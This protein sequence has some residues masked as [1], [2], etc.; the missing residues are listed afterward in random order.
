MNSEQDRCDPR[1]KNFRGAISRHK[2]KQQL[3][4]NRAS[5]QPVDTLPRS[6]SN[7]G[8]KISRI[9]S[10]SQD[11]L[12]R[13][14]SN[15]L[16]SA[17]LQS[18]F[19]A[20]IPSRITQPGA[21]KSIRVCFLLSMVLFA[22]TSL[23]MGGL[24]VFLYPIWWLCAV[25]WVFS[26]VP[27]VFSCVTSIT[28]STL[29]LSGT[30]I[31]NLVNVFAAIAVVCVVMTEVSAASGTCKG[32]ETEGQPCGSF[33]N[34]DQLRHLSANRAIVTALVTLYGIACVICNGTG[35][36]YSFFLARKCK[37]QSPNWLTS[38]SLKRPSNR[39]LPGS[40]AVHIIV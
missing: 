36:V 29:W 11:R 28:G 1:F 31:S 32:R 17:P 35:M 30:T 40:T 5:S 9:T 34:S 2:E 27:V 26:G 15:P 20:C 21:R 10:F 13:G 33:F 25:A 18:E 8:E 16:D 37:R 7:P 6:S 22:F 14:S 23:C 39:V 12:T 19:L 38:I 24:A 4:L 3:G